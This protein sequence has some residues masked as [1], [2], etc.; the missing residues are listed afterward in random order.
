LFVAIPGVDLGAH[1][2]ATDR[3]AAVILGDIL[4]EHIQGEPLADQHII[5]RAKMKSRAQV[6]GTI[7]KVYYPLVLSPLPQSNQLVALYHPK[8]LYKKKMK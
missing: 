7:A 6:V 2:A 1:A 8:E 3:V 5:A 4:K